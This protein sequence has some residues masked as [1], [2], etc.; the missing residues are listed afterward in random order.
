MPFERTT[1]PTYSPPDKRLRPPF[2]RMPALPIAAKVLS[3][4]G[5]F[6]AALVAQVDQARV[7]GWIGNLVGFPTRHTLSPHNV[8]AAQWLRG[9]FQALGYADVVFHDF[10]HGGLAIMSSVTSPVAWIPANTFSS[11]RITTRAGTTFRIPSQRRLEP[12]TTP[13]VSRHCWK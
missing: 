13:R 1:V 10:I 11:V 12:M 5:E 6:V 4:F 8:E 7:S 9:R 2:P 3:P